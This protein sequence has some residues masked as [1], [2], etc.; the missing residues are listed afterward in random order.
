MEN[1]KQKWSSTAQKKEQYLQ[2][3]SQLEDTIRINIDIPSST[4][5]GW[6]KKDNQ[7]SVVWMENHPVPESVLRLITCTCRK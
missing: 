4:G 6:E 1:E 2:S 7:L 3:R 5:H